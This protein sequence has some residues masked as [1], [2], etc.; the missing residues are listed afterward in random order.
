MARLLQKAKPVFLSLFLAYLFSFLAGYSA[1]KLD[2][3][4]YET[5]INRD[6][7][8][9]SRTLEY[10][11]PGYGSVLQSYKEHHRRLMNSLASNKNF[12][13]MG[14]LIFLNNFVVANIT[15]IVRAIFIFPLF[16]NIAGKFLQGVI[17]AQTPGPP[18]I[19]IMF[20]MEFGGYFLT[21]FAALTGVLW[22]IFSRGFGFS[23]R[24]KAFLGGLRL[25]GIMY[26]VSGIGI[27]LGSVAE[28][29][30]LRNL[31]L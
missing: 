18:M 11:I 7:F 23:S 13:G 5:L 4:R 17:M 27:L 28:T 31:L 1:G 26:L 6:V 19:Y 15:M 8:K 21:S 22:T 3:V 2:Y 24:R 30:F 25:L 9:I 29:L 10:R 14:I 20:I 16:L 12:T